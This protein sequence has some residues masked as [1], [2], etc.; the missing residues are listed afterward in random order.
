MRPYA[1]PLAAATLMLLTA[2]SPTRAEIVTGT[3]QGQISS[4]LGA[5]PGLAV[6]SPVTGTYSYDASGPLSGGTAPFTALNLTIG[7]NPQP[8]TLADL[9]QPP[10]SPSGRVTNG[11]ISGRD[12][13][14]F[15]FTD[16][17]LTRF[18]G[19]PGTWG[20]GVLFNNPESYFARAGD[21]FFRFEFTAAPNAP[22]VAVPEPGAAALLLAGMTACALGVRGRRRADGEVREVR[23][24]TAG[25]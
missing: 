20:Q 13:L 4:L 14:L 21:T 12:V 2:A 18:T 11:S 16:E 19:T 3:I 25:G 23:P 24:S 1:L 9:R 17:A 22:S 10:A 8:F 7:A 15:L 6:G 5:V